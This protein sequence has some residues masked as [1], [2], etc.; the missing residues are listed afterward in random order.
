M[1]Q[2]QLINGQTLAWINPGEYIESTFKQDQSFIMLVNRLKR[3][4]RNV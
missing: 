1:P 2:P 3:Q 4:Y